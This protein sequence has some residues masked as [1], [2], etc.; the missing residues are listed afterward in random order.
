MVCRFIHWHIWETTVFLSVRGWRVLCFDGA[1]V[2]LYG[3]EGWQP[4]PDRKIFTTKC[5]WV[6]KRLWSPGK[7]CHWFQRTSSLKEKQLPNL[8][9]G[10]ITS[11][12]LPN[13][14]L[15]SI[16][17]KTSGRANP[18]EWMLGTTVPFLLRHALW[19]VGRW[20]GL[21]LALATVP[22]Q[23]RSCVQWPVAFPIILFWPSNCWLLSG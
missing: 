12:T 20:P 10:S 11:K 22:T 7:F 6:K 13:L 9:L 17:S 19:D 18:L 2:R 21:C 14:C 4:R 15:G 16:T 3:R 1:C 5:Q 23:K 8:C